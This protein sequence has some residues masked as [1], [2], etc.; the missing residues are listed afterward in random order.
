MGK[1]KTHFAKIYIG[2]TITKPYFGILYYDPETKDYCEGF[3]SYDILNVFQ[4]LREEFEIVDE[5]E[6]EDEEGNKNGK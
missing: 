1:I 4:W 2:G 5:P 6:T 3:G